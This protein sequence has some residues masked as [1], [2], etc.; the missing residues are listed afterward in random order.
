MR[1]TPGSYAFKAINDALDGMP[2]GQISPV[3]EGPDSF[4]IVK[5]EN[6]RPAGPASFEDVQDKIKPMLQSQRMNQESEAFIRKLKENT[7]IEDYLD[8]LDPRKS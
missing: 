3:I 4:H 6:R 1:T 7:L 2:I 8:K 5:V